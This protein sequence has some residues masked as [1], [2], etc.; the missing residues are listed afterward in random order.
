MPYSKRKNANIWSKYAIQGEFRRYDGQV[1]NCL[2]MLC[3]TPFPKSIK[4][5]RFWIPTGE[6]RTIKVRD[7]EKIQQANSD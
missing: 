2:G 3:R 1:L 4:I 5:K 6:I 7:G